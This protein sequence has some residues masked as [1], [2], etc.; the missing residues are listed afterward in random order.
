MGV[1]RHGDLSQN[2]P[3]QPKISRADVAD[4]MLK[5]LSDDTYVHQ[6]PGVQY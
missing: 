4:F 1:Y 6:M 3:L 2:E 5:Q